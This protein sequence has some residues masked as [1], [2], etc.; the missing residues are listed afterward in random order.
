MAF[1]VSLMWNWHHHRRDIMVLFYRIQLRPRALPAAL[2][3]RVRLAMRWVVRQTARLH[4][5]AGRLVIGAR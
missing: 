2:R 5:L 1:A 4:P 3:A